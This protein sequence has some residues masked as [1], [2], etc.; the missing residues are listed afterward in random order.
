MEVTRGEGRCELCKVKFHFAPQ[1][2]E[3]APDQLSLGEVL[4]GLGS[5]AVV[6]WLPFT[7]RLALCVFL[8]LLVA[9]LMTSYLYLIWMHRSISMITERFT[10]NLLPTDTVSGAVLA[11]VVL[12]SFL[13]LM[14]FADFLRVEW[15][16]MHDNQ[17]NPRADRPDPMDPDGRRRAR[18]ELADAAENDRRRRVEVDNELVERFRELRKS[19]NQQQQEPESDAENTASRDRDSV[20]DS[21]PSEDQPVE[22]S[23]PVPAAVNDVEDNNGDQNEQQQDNDN[24]IDDDDDDDDDGP[25]LPQQGERPQPPPQ[26]ARPRPNP[27]P[28]R[29]FNAEDF[30]PLPQDDQMVSM[31]DDLFS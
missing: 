22:D 6:R 1:Y 17:N 29:Q 16:Q 13:S 7:L 12:V 27:A 15:Q 28:P 25:R 4:L 31:I 5:R 14:S 3:D 30:D 26:N 19:N 10:W 9:P 18:Q 24:N 23:T 20:A 8:W 2:A 21:K 11:A